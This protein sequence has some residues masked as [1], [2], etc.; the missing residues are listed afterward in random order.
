VGAELGCCGTVWIWQVLC[1]IHLCCDNIC[2]RSYGKR[3][4]GFVY[5]FFR[6]LRICWNQN[7][8]VI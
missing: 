8:F 1:S 3:N 7:V 6:T 5:A 2:S 4:T